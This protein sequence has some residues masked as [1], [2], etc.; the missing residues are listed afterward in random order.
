[1]KIPPTNPNDLLP[2]GYNDTTEMNR[3][4]FLAATATGVTLSVA[5]CV[6]AG[7]LGSSEASEHT[8]LDPPEHYEKLQ[9]SRDAGHLAFPIHGDELPDVTVPDALSGAK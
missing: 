6:D 1:M 8:V 2:T 9:S 5:G 4:R 7:P 3:R